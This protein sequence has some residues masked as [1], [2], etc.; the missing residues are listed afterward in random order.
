V[1]EPPAGSPYPSFHDKGARFG[2]HNLHHW[3]NNP[4][5]ESRDDRLYLAYFNAGLRVFDIADPYRPQ[6]IAYYVP[7]DPP[8]RRGLLPDKLVTQSEDVLVDSRGYIYVTDKNWGVHILE[9]TGAE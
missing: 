3:Q 2:P 7:P 9:Y 4:H 5:L 1:P 6:E 8:L